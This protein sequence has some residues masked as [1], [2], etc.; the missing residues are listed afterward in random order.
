VT[1]H[2]LRHSFT[3]LAPDLGYS[4]PTIGT[5]VGHKD[6]TVTSRYLHSADAVLLSAA[7]A[8]AIKTTA[9]MSGNKGAVEVI[10]LRR[11]SA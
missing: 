1:P 8:V 4:E 7:D 11:E 9:L 6:R 3:S 5:L 10:P 2:A